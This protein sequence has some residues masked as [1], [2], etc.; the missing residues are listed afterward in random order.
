MIVETRMEGKMASWYALCDYRVRSQRKL[1][2]HQALDEWPR[3]ESS[4]AAVREYLEDAV[5]ASFVQ[6]PDH[7]GVA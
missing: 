6:S 2:K 3:K 1:A 5:A 7:D 4:F